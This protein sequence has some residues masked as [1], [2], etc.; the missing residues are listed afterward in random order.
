MKLHDPTGLSIRTAYLSMFEFIRRYHERGPSE[1]T[2]ILLGELSL[3]PDGDSADPAHYH[4]F[5]ESVREV[6]R[7][8]ASGGYQEARFRLQPPRS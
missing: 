7:A 5:E 8:E 2:A 6:M 4:D 1:E 3:P